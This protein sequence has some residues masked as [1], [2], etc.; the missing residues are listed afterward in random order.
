MKSKF[1]LILLLLL[2]GCAKKVVAPVPGTINTFD[3]YSARVVGDAQEALRSAKAWELCS[4][5]GSAP[6]VTFD[7]IT[8]PCD[9]TAP[10]F[11]AAGRPILFK[12][13][14]SYNVALAAGQAYHSGASSDTAGL[15]QAL[16]TLS[17][18]IGDLLTGIGRAK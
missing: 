4:D 17:L 18:A 7:G 10:K 9:A 16:T 14:Q 1:G 12:A 11:P 8:R 5:S 6:A 2:T 13:E 3:A 15:T